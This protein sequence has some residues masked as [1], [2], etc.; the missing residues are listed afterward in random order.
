MKF[1]YPLKGNNNNSLG[2]S[3]FD[4]PGSNLPSS[5]YPP[6]NAGCAGVWG[7]VVAFS[8]NPR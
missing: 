2:L 1:T 7:R 6:P 4:Y 8:I 3:Y 5:P